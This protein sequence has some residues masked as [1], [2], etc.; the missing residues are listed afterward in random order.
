MILT[1]KLRGF[2]NMG[3]VEE[4]KKKDKLLAMIIRNDYFCEGVEFITPN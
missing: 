4:I 3:Q 2:E 1:V